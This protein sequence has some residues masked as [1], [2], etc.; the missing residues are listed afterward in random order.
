[1][2]Q[3]DETE[4]LEDFGGDDLLAPDRPEVPASRRPAPPSAEF[5]ELATK[6]RGS[7]SRIEKG[8]IAFDVLSASMAD[9]LEDQTLTAVDRR[10][11]L[12]TIAAAAAKV[13]PAKELHE[14]TLKVDAYLAQIDTR[15]RA[16]VGAELERRTAALGPKIG[17]V[18]QIRGSA[19]PG[20]GKSD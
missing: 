18:I 7:S 13:L 12:R 16:R 11:E 15:K 9:V 6:I 20:G 5:L 19:V 17:K 10:R 3:A 2:D 8:A 4:E 1:M 14:A